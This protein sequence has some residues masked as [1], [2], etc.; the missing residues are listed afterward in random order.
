MIS[1]VGEVV[2]DL[3]EQ[4]D[5]AFLA[6]PG[7]SPANVALA[8]ARL[9]HGV[10]LFARFGPDVFARR[11]R[12]HLAANRVGLD[13]AVAAVQPSTLAVASMDAQGRAT[14]DFWTEGTADWQWT[15]AELSAALGPQVRALHTGSLASWTPPG[16]AAVNRLLRRARTEDGTTVCYDPNVRPS[17]LGSPE[18]ARPLVEPLMAL[19]H[20][21]KASDED[22]AWLYPG[23]TAGEAAER[24][25]ALGPA[26][27]V[28]T[29]GPDGALA[30][31]GADE[32]AVPA[33][34]VRVADTVGAGDTFTAGLLHALAE[35]DRLGAAPTTRLA[36]MTADELAEVLRVAATAA[37]LTCSRHGCDP[38]TAA[39]LTAQLSG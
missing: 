23:S 19:A 39:E 16:S 6:H 34:P 12:E 9:G 25:Q 26:L 18:A 35:R 3:V 1:V 5:G 27:V 21:V 14:Y 32:V 38:P 20:V 30:R 8:L 17:L 28:V 36:A 24:V 13:R 37:A 11:A 2:A 7:G 15:D 22:L 33:P 31:H 4:A 29:L 10:S